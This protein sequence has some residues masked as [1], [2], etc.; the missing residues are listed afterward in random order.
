[1]GERDLKG[2]LVAARD[3]GKEWNS[4]AQLH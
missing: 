1:L 3:A 4:G 2:A